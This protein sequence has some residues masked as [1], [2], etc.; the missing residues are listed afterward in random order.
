MSGNGST[1]VEA[2]CP[3]CDETVDAYRTV[4]WQDN[5]CTECGSTNVEAQQ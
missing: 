3:Q 1:T 2:F 4:P 5:V